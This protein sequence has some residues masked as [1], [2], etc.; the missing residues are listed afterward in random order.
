MEERLTN[1]GEVFVLPIDKKE[2][3]YER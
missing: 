1:T 3:V 2:G